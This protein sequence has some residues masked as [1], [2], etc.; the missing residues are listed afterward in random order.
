[1]RND[2]IR[3]AYTS[4]VSVETIRDTQLELLSE[5]YEQDISVPF[6]L[7]VCSEGGHME[8]GLALVSTIH[9]IRRDGRYVTTHAAGGAYSMGSVI[10]QAGDHRT[11]DAFGTVMT[12]E[13]SISELS[14]SLSSADAYVKQ[15]FRAKE[16]I[17]SIFSER[18]GHDEEFLRANLFTGSDVYF[19]AK[20][21]LDYNL[22]DEIVPIPTSKLLLSN[23]VL[24]RPKG[25]DT[26]LKRAA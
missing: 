19:S 12:H 22:V 16:I 14:D 21:A 17:I 3:F 23:K 25:R 11:I 20:D 10:L 6:H 1:M 5:H 26:R 8:A 24:R 13:P 7:S 9:Q 2:P 15:V 4:E 18:T